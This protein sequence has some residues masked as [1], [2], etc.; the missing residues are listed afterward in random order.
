RIALTEID[1]I[2]KLPLSTPTR[3]PYPMPR[4]RLPTRGA[5]G[6]TDSLSSPVGRRV[7]EAR[8]STVNRPPESPGQTP[9]PASTTGAGTPPEIAFCVVSGFGTV[10]FTTFTRNE[11]NRWPRP[12]RARAVPSSGLPPL[13]AMPASGWNV[14]YASTAALQAAWT[15]AFASLHFGSWA[16]SG[17]AA[18]PRSAGIHVVPRILSPYRS[19][20][21]TPDAPAFT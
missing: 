7:A 18:R 8:T 13:I 19:A 16:A 20:K 10:A 9:R 11:P 5:F 3:T 6:S 21:R 2:G 12:P 17:T 4:A 15:W 14:V 1:G